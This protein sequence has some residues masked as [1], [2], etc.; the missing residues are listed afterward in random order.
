MAH[1]T[2]KSAYK[3]L[4][5]RINRFPQGA[6]PSKLLF[7]ILEML[8][9]EREAGLVAQLPIKP[10]TALKADR[11]WKLGINESR[12]VLDELASRG[13]LIDMEIRGTTIYVLPPPMAGFFE[14]SLMRIR[15]DIDQ[16]LLSEL[17]HQYLNVEEDFIKAL[18]ATGETQL[19][20]AFVHEP[21]LSAENA[22]HVLDYERSSHVVDT[23]K[24]IGIGACYCRHKMQ[25][26]DRSCD[27]PMNICMTFGGTAASLTRH[28][29]ARKVDRAEARDLLDEAYERNLVQFGENVQRR[30]SFICNCCGCC[31]EAMIAARKFGIL[32]PV[33][34]TNFLPVVRQESCNG[35]G[36][37]VAAC[38][39]EAIALVSANDPHRPGL[40]LARVE[41]EVCLG[42]GVCVRNCNID[43]LAFKSRPERIMTPLTTTRRTVLMAIERGTLQNLI[44]DNQVL[45]SRR[46]LA[47]MLGVIL[48][49]PPVK[50]AMA[51]KQI[52]SRYLEWAERK[53][54]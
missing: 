17:F 45:M 5:D 23:A 11:I 24:H 1:L 14:F 16:K 7:Q 40:K 29:I 22:I 37:C 19:G 4:S 30:V 3:N 2:P 32:Q 50:R 6:P 27:A 36:K 47:A 38:P 48:K 44:F 42:C 54:Q 43:A 21:V 34:T 53:V 8:F 39:V 13:I 52:Q 18:F 33:H 41:E 46:A 12:K 26:L 15:D 51:S 10:F 49:L 25:H 9:S 20:R 31:C 35:C 28:G